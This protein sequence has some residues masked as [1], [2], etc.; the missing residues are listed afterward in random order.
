MTEEKGSIPPDFGGPDEILLCEITGTEKIDK[1]IINSVESNYKG[2]VKFI[3]HNEL[4]DKYSDMTKY[5]FVI[6]RE[7][8]ERNEAI[9]NR[10]SI[11]D[12]SSDKLYFCG[13][14]SSNYGTLYAAYAIQLEKKR[15]SQK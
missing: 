3:F 12:R 7:V 10:I 2:E 5:K 1:Y 9:S 11:R 14:T 8:I 15:L 6:E 4:E 13:V